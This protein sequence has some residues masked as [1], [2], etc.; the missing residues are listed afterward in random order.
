SIGG[1]NQLKLR[2]GDQVSIRDALYCSVLGSN[3]W[4]AEALAYHV[5]KDLLVR[6]G[7]S[8]DPVKEFVKHMNALAAEHGSR[9]TRF[10]NPHGMDHQ[11]KVPYSTAGDV[12]RLTIC[13][14][15]KAAF[16]FICSQAERK[17]SI[18]SVGGRKEFIVKNTNKIL[19]VDGID[20]VKTGLTS[21]AGPCLVVTAAK[22]PI[23]SELADGNK[24]VTPR[25]LVVVV[26]GAS[27]RFGAARSLLLRGWQKFETWNRSGRQIRD[28]A[29]LLSI[30]KE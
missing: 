21:R 2:P 10:I 23:V 30:S 14:M 5:G 8:G 24:Q 17:V 20:G 1:P 18:V 6:G 3:N 13:A 25:R 27:D 12:A 7:K 9:Y 16:S 15:G 29:E 28:R 19:N 22:Q 11:G 4:T 26:L